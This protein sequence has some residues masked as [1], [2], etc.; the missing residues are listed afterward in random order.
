MANEIGLVLQHVGDAPTAARAALACKEITLNPLNYI[1]RHALLQS[2]CAPLQWGRSFT[3]PTPCPGSSACNTQLTQGEWNKRMFFLYSRIGLLWS[4][5]SVDIRAIY[6]DPRFTRDVCLA[7]NELDPHAVCARHLRISA[8]TS[9][10]SANA[11]VALMAGRRSVSLDLD[12]TLS[13]PATTQHVVG[14]L[15]PHLRSLTIFIDSKQTLVALQQMLHKRRKQQP[16]APLQHLTVFSSG[17]KRLG[18]L[19]HVVTATFADIRDCRVIHDIDAVDH[20]ILGH[21]QDLVRLA[22]IH[23]WALSGTCSRLAALDHVHVMGEVALSSDCLRTAKGLS[24]AGAKVLLTSPTLDGVRALRSVRCV[25][26][27]GC[28]T[29]VDVAQL[30]A[31]HDVSLIQCDHVRDLRALSRVRCLTLQGGQTPSSPQ[32]VPPPP[33]PPLLLLLPVF[34]RLQR[35]SLINVDGVRR[36]DVAGDTLTSVGLFGTPLSAVPRMQGSGAAQLLHLSQTSVADLSGVASVRRLVLNNEGT[37]TGCRVQAA[38]LISDL[39]R[40]LGQAEELVLQGTASLE[41]LAARIPGQADGP[42]GA[43]N[44]VLPNLRVLEV[45]DIAVRAAHHQRCGRSEQQMVLVPARLPGLLLLRAESVWACE[46]LPGLLD[47][48][49]VQQLV[50][51]CNLERTTGSMRLAAVLPSYPA[52]KELHVWAAGVGEELR[53]A[54]GSR[55]V[56]LFDHR[57]RTFAEKGNHDC[58]AAAALEQGVG[59]LNVESAVENQASMEATADVQWTEYSGFV[60]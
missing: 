29:L 14:L 8:H 7:I 28:Q 34:E 40:I 45:T 41:A 10:C 15:G 42:A 50:V 44:A 56:A 36:V 1:C 13:R 35:L 37:A 31:V 21:A 53:Q 55:G 27:M 23:V 60:L 33:P 46:V 54:A 20:L 4:A 18:C 3:D 47:V 22:R 2:D 17:M 38:S 25:M 30:A 51:T 19:S 58:W 9:L 59:A 57:T 6:S 16:H 48:T 43:G 49:R 24:V 26:L 52:L 39:A 11:C 5:H 32:S 12:L